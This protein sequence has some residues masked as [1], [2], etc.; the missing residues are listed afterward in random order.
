[1]CRSLAVITRPVGDCCHGEHESAR[2]RHPGDDGQL[3]QLDAVAGTNH[4]RR[5]HRP[6][7]SESATAI[8]RIGKRTSRT[9]PQRNT[10][11]KPK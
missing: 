11:C 9:G 1:M 7:T 2:F 8:A 3:R 5:R 4:D 10:R 6:A